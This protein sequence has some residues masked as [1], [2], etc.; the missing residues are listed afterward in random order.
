MT[1]ENKAATYL[2]RV[3]SDHEDEGEVVHPESEVE[4]LVGVAEEDNVLDSVLC[5]RR[6]LRYRPNYISGR[7]SGAKG[8]NG[9]LSSTRTLNADS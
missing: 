5:S 8:G 4:Q 2:L 3:L 7:S 9:P 6:V 1:G